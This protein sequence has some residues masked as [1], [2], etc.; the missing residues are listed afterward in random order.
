MIDHE[1]E[2]KKPVHYDFGLILTPSKHIV[3][4]TRLWRIGSGWPGLDKNGNVLNKINPDL[5]KG[6]NS[7]RFFHSPELPPF[8][9]DY[10]TTVMLPCWKL[11]TPQNGNPTPSEPELKY[12]D[13]WLANT[14]KTIG[15]SPMLWYDALFSM[16]HLPQAVDFIFDWESNPIT[17][18]PVEQLGSYMCPTDAWI[19]YYLYGVANRMKQ[20]VKSFYMDLT[21]FKPCSNR[22]HGCGYWDDS[23]TLQGIIPFLKTREMFLRFQKMVKENDPD[24]LLVLHG[25]SASPSLYLDGC[26]H[27]WRSVD[28]RS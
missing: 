21:F 2:I 3:N 15:G 10:L 18:L 7:R 16:Y 12:I 11:R 17:R 27:R 6:R 24:G 26:N 9:K 8:T 13:K 25:S 28:Y 19:D 14:K 5:F 4:K 22:F 1:S 20:G 23:E